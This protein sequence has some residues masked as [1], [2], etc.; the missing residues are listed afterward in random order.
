[1]SWFLNTF[2]CHFGNIPG[3]LP[4]WDSK[5]PQWFKCDLENEKI[6]SKCDL[7]NEKKMKK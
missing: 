5:V 6:S 3:I 7:E 4:K 2:E 1:M